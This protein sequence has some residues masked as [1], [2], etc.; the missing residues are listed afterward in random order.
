MKERGNNL[1]KKMKHFRETWFY[2]NTKD[3]EKLTNFHKMVKHTQKILQQMLQGFSRVLNH[4]LDTR[5]YRVKFA[6]Y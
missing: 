1:Y 5:R 3:S 6:G 4:L 2:Y